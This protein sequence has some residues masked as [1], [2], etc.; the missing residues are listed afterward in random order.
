M[1]SK[2]GDENWVL[3]VNQKIKVGIP[4]EVARLSWGEPDEINHSNSG[5]Q[6]VYNGQYLYFENGKL[7]AWN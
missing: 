1:K 3:I 5:D 6:W 7:T 2:Y 4:E